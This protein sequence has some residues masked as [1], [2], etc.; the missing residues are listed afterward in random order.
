M[1]AIIGNRCRRRQLFGAKF[2]GIAALSAAFS[3]AAPARADPLDE[4]KRLY[5]ELD[6]D[7]ARAELQR[8]T[9]LPDRHRRGEAYLYLGLIATGEGDDAAAR[10]SFRAG[11]ALDPELELP[12]GTS[13]KVARIFDRLRADVR[14]HPPPQPP[15]PPPTPVVVQRPAPPPV[16]SA[17][18]NEPQPLPPRVL[19]LSPS[20]QGEGEVAGA[21]PAPSHA[22]RWV[23]GTL[24][25]LGVAAAATGIVWGVQESAAETSFKA[26]KFQNAAQPYS[27]AANQDALVA[28]VLYASGAVVGLTGLG[29]WFAF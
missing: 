24:F 23:A 14:R 26:Q 11:L 22:G 28:D 1:T 15:E 25:L 27:T 7:A 2:L 18:P 6:Y 16:A 10:R 12:L 9:A 20:A 5:H 3:A 21:A 29:L 19:Q 4:G 8:A 17:P 13:P